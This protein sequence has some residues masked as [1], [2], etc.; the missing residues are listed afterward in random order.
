MGAGGNPA[1]TTAKEE[2]KMSNLKF[3]IE[4]EC[5]TGL[6]HDEMRHALSRRGLGTWD[7][8]YDGSIRGTGTA[9]ELVSPILTIEDARA[10]VP[11]VCETL[12]TARAMVNSSCGFHVHVS[13]LESVEARMVRNVARPDMSAEDIIRL[14]LQSTIKS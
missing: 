6:S 9:T 7:V 8:K 13:G 3:G 4:L 10:A 1:T 2:T 5:T 11:M 14:A 12:R